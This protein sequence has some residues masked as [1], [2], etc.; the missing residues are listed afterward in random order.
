[1]NRNRQE[2]LQKLAFAFLNLLMSD[3]YLN[4][5]N[6]RPFGNSDVDQDVLKIIGCK[7]EPDAEDNM[8]YSEEQY[9]YARKLFYHEL[10]PFLKSKL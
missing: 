3:G 6:K 4:L 10:V 7:L 8:C 1:M 5:D 2:D 9:D